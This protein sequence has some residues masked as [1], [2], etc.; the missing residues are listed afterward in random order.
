ML[1]V[2]R[3]FTL[4]HYYYYYY[5]KFS[6]V[7]RW[8]IVKSRSWQYIKAIHP[9]SLWIIIIII[10]IIFEK[11]NVIPGICNQN[12]YHQFTFSVAN[13]F[14]IYIYQCLQSHTTHVCDHVLFGNFCFVTGGCQLVSDRE[15]MCCVWL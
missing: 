9:S 1:N 2:L 11:S 7:S 8:H 4:V 5:I 10:F 15:R 3:T 14:L 6:P 13:H 12:C